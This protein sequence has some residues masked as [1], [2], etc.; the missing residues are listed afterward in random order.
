MISQQKSVRSSNTHTHIHTGS[1][2]MTHR[3]EHALRKRKSLEPDRE[4]HVA[5][6][7]DVLHLE[8][9]EGRGEAELG[10]NLCVL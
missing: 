9:L 5:R 3:C 4:A 8:L 7:D 2:M 1:G 6:P 10:H